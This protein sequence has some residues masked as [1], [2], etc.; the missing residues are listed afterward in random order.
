MRKY[1][2]FFLLFIGALSQSIAQS[3]PN[4][5]ITIER[6]LDIRAALKLARQSTY[7]ITTKTQVFGEGNMYKVSMY[8]RG[9]YQNGG[10]DDK[11]IYGQQLY[12][13]VHGVQ[14]TGWSMPTNNSILG[15]FFSPVPW[16][17]NERRW[18][19]TKI[20]RS[21]QD[22]ITL[23]D[24]EYVPMA[25][26]TGNKLP[27]TIVLELYGDAR[28]TNIEEIRLPGIAPLTYA[29][30]P[31]YIR[32]IEFE[33]AQLSAGE[34][35]SVQTGSTT[36]ILE[37]T[38]VSSEYSGYQF[39]APTTSDPLYKI[40][41][42]QQKVR[43]LAKN[44]QQLTESWSLLLPV[45]HVGY[46]LVTSSQVATIHGS[47]YFMYEVSVPEVPL[48]INGTA[49]GPYVVES[50]I[51]LKPF[52]QNDSNTKLL[53]RDQHTSDIL[54]AAH[55]GFWQEAELVENTMEAYDRARSMNVD[56]LEVDVRQ[57]FDGKYILF[58]DSYADRLLYFTAGED[59]S[60]YAEVDITQFSYKK[61]RVDPGSG[62]ELPA[63]KDAKMKDRF[64]T[65]TEE[66][67]L[68][69]DD[70]IA[71]VQQ[72]HVL[73]SL[74]HA[75]DYLAPIHRKL[76]EANVEDY[77]F[78]KGN[79]KSDPDYFKDTHGVIMQQIAYTPVFYEWAF[80]DLAKGQPI[81][82]DAAAFW[83]K[84]KT[85]EQELGWTVPGCEIIFK[86]EIKGDNEPEPYGPIPLKSKDYGV[87]HTQHQE[88]LTFVQQINDTHWVGLSAWFPLYCDDPWSPE[89][90]S[91]SKNFAP[92]YDWRADMSFCIDY[93]HLNYFITDRPKYTLDYWAAR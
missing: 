35:F 74:D 17:S 10:G 8:N 40:A 29:D 90:P 7:G 31:I 25:S 16:K 81:N 28:S 68:T 41:A 12:W 37:V 49:E 21:I 42:P 86:K 79:G 65:E 78:W 87:S 88:A 93:C 47:A 92:I 53:R 69:L 48:L 50:K 75:F 19:R 13:N 76:L 62:L 26:Y 55:R 91:N 77:F 23:L 15:Y 18:Y 22:Q 5:V 44:E 45:G 27:V 33:I 32:G 71:Y 82:Y 63:L 4:E 61:G 46:S 57:T 20:N 59:M 36:E 6:D 14:H 58:H 38:H 70:L 80:E 89:E 3:P 64:K 11:V 9:D 85:Y 83:Q 56:M 39:T 30:F 34:S 51:K 52:Q 60:K 84:F 72:H 73:I 43:L 67:L 1:C 2:S 66:T 54:V 24:P